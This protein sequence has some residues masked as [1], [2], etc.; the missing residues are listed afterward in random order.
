VTSVSHDLNTSIKI[1]TCTFKEINMRASEH[2]VFL[3]DFYYR[4]IYNL[5]SVREVTHTSIQNA[6]DANNLIIAYKRPW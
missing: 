5:S 4:Y 1:W 6:I 2:C 3:P